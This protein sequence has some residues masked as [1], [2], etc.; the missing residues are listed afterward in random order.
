MRAEQTVISN[1]PLLKTGRFLANFAVLKAVREVDFKIQQDEI[2]SIIGPSGA[3]R[4]QPA[5]E[6]KI[7]L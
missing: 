7:G 3:G 1:Q 5:G 4:L 6:R 2:H